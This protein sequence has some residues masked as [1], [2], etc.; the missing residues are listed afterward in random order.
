MNCKK[1]NGRCIKNGFQVNG[2][3]RYICKECRINQQAIYKYNA[4]NKDLNESIVKLVANS[5]GIRDISR[6]LSISKTT[7]I[8]K[9]LTIANSI[10]RTR[11]NESKQIYEVDELSVKMKGMK[12]C[13]I[14][15]AINRKTRQIVDFNVGSN[16]KEKLGKIINSVL[17]LN[18]KKIYTDRLTTYKNLIPEDVHSNR[19]YQTNIIERYNLNLRTHIKRISR[20]TICFSRNIK[21]LKASVKIYFWYANNNNTI[22]LQ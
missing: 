20:K 18:P 19:K 21:M 15:Y 5:C 7:V 22:K 10:N 3:Q 11:F 12:R 6:V 8:N 4:Y 16:T 17:R 1:C 2:R 13:W 14:M 9:I